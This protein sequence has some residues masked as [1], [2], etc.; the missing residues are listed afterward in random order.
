MARKKSGDVVSFASK[1]LVGIEGGKSEDNSDLFGHIQIKSPS[2]DVLFESDIVSCGWAE[3]DTTHYFVGAIDAEGNV[4]NH[5]FL[6]GQSFVHIT[7]I[8][9]KDKKQTQ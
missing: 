3:G 4:T 5:L 9:N 8:E 1:Q 6:L 2:G 7:K